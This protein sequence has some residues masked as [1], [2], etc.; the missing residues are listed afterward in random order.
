MLSQLIIITLFRGIPEAFIHMFGIYAFAGKR[1][2]KNKYLLSSLIVA[3][4]MVLVSILPI[5]NGI[6]TILILMI[7]S[8]VATFINGFGS[9]Y[10]VSVA[11]IN[12]II[13]FIAEGLNILLIELVFK[14]DIQEAIATPL[15]KAVYG[16]PS[17]IIF[18]GV[19][20]IITSMIKKR[21]LNE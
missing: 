15:S 4:S 7:I 3:V 20:V 5:S 21:R 18:F 8:A 2:D 6:H 14:K 17:L 9:V 11:I 1:I 10:C 16:I 13:Q 19:I 12:I